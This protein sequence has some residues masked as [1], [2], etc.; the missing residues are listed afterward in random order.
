MADQ[1]DIRVK[2]QDNS[3]FPSI[4]ENALII[5]FFVIFLLCRVICKNFFMD[6]V[7]LLKTFKNI[8]LQP[9]PRNSLRVIIATL[10]KP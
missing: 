8:A 3:K 7:R 2:D 4:F 10:L 6:V 9:P 1:N 5:D